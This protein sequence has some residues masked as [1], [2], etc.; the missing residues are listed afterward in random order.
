MHP[1][2]TTMAAEPVSGPNSPSSNAGPPAAAQGLSRSDAGV[3]DLRQDLNERHEQWLREQYLRDLAA[4]EQGG[5][6]FTA[7]GQLHAVRGRVA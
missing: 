5:C 3:S 1:T 2:P 7:M 6:F 4:M